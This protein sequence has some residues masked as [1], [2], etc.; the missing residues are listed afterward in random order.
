MYAKLAS[1][2]WR[3]NAA[4]VFESE[5]TSVARV[6]D[7][8][9]VTGVSNG[10][11][12]VRC[13]YEGVVF[14]TCVYVENAVLVEEGELHRGNG[15]SYTLRMKAGSTQRLRFRTGEGFGV[16]QPV[17]FKSNKNNIAFVDEYGVIEAR[18]AGKAVISTKLNGK[19]ITIKLVVEAV[20][21]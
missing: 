10:M 1:F 20:Q 17:L 6:D 15:N 4:A 16:F 12:V 3:K 2:L 19:K 11:T 13:T 14:R 21:E 7:K 9:T 5:D 18:K 8:G